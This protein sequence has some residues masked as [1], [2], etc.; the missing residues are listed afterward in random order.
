M[1]TKEPCLNTLTDSQ[2]ASGNSS[3]FSGLPAN[4][5]IETIPF[6]AG[7]GMACNLKRI[8]NP[9]NTSRGPVLLV[10]GAGV[11]AQIFSAPTQMNFVRYLVERGY[12]VWLENWRASI[13]LAFNRWTLDQAALHDHP[14]AVKK[15]VESTG[16][17]Q[18]PAVIHCQGSTSFTMSLMAGLLPQIKT[19]ISN[20][21]S[22]HPVVPWLSKAKLNFAV[23]SASLFIDH[24]NPQWGLERSGI[25]PH[26]LTAVVELTHH[27]CNNAVCKQ[28]SFAYGSGFPA[29][30][31][32]KNLDETTHEWL[33]H[34]FAKVPMSFFQQ[35]ARCVNAGHL[36]SMGLESIKDQSGPGSKKL[37]ADFTAQKPETEARIAF[38]SGRDNLCFLPQ[39]QKLSY[40]FFLRTRKDHSHYEIPGYGHLD[41][42]MGEHAARDIFPLMVAE[43]EKGN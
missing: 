5:I 36:V 3:S 14:M 7:D 15:V 30:W 2:P 35:M 25:M 31:S 17:S 8:Y 26:L 4:F 13:D 37:P 1:D 41:M 28:V 11:R 9:A 12:D 23:P 33:K 16:V 19:V 42:F 20:A 43:L 29:L 21:V 32:H 27:E 22:L 10:H 39:S 40:E 18:L 24:L 38:F 6:Q 34:E